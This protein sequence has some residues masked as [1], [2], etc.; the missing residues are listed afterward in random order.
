MAAAAMF[1]MAPVAAVSVMGPIMVLPGAMMASMGAVIVAV[2]AIAVVARV[3]SSIHHAAAISGVIGTVIVGIAI[4][5]VIRT[6]V[7]ASR[8]GKAEDRRGG[9]QH[10]SF[11]SHSG[12]LSPR[13][14]YGVGGEEGKMIE[15]VMKRD[16]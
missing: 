1:G 9:R 8:E 10:Q 11:R 5:A 2:A 12:F 7:H 13:L 15:A 14:K 3:I 4:G 16:R 6:A